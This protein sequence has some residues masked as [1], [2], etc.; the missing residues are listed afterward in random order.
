MI[1]IEKIFLFPK[2]GKKLQTKMNKSCLWYQKFTRKGYEKY[3]IDGSSTILLKCF[4]V[5][6]D[7]SLVCNEEKNLETQNIFQSKHPAPLE[8]NR[9]NKHY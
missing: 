8:T 6:V 7:V 5:I 4:V 9:V 2:K 3:V 1:K